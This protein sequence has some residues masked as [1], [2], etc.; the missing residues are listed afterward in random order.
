V[1]TD[2]VR[3]MVRTTA[4]LSAIGFLSALALFA[5]RFG[6]RPRK[7]GDAIGLLTS[8]IV[9]H[10][11]HFG[12]VARLARLTAGENIREPGGWPRVWGRGGST[13]WASWRWRWW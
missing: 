12:A 8:F 5:A 3:L 11:I 2:Q 7:V 10:T 9:L 4:R 1:D 13:G 6:P